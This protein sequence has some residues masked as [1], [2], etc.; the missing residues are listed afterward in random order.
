MHDQMKWTNPKHAKHLN[1]FTLLEI[2]IAILILAT[3]LS[4]VFASYTG[5]FRIVGETESQAEIYQMAGIAF[6]RIIEDLECY[7][8]PQ[9]V[10]TTESKDAEKSLEFA[11]EE[12]EIQAR[13]ADTL[14]FPSRAH[15]VFGDQGESWGIAEISYYVEEG[16]EEEGLVLYRSDRLH[17]EATSEEAGGGLPL[18][19]RLLSV[20]FTYYDAKGEESESWDQSSEEGTPQLPQRVSISLEFINP[21]DP[22]MP[23][24]FT[25][26][27]ALHISKEEQEEE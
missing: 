25:T 19:E 26:S 4:T 11:G 14:R 12:N 8:V 6:E 13:S 20:D 15:V 18:C 3:V 17:L 16:S 27:V 23:L 10:E 9:K 7:Y 2:L 21:S 24:K 5:T 1:G 22:E